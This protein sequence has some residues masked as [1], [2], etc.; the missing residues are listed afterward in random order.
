MSTSFEFGDSVDWKTNPVCQLL[1]SQTAMVSDLGEVAAD[2]PHNRQVRCRRHR[3][4][5]RANMEPRLYTIRRQRPLISTGPP[6]QDRRNACKGKRHDYGR[7]IYNGSIEKNR[8]RP[9]R[10]ALKPPGPE[11]VSRYMTSVPFVALIACPPDD[12]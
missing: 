10:A 2:C 1:L 6:G 7:S 12:W 8:Q 9:V 3:A 5:V 4:H 11:P